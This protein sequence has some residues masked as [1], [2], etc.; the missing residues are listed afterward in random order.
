MQFEVKKQSR[1]TMRSALLKGFHLELTQH[2][3]FFGLL[4]LL[5]SYFKTLFKREFPL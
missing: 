4:T 3:S 2:L 5:H 1:R